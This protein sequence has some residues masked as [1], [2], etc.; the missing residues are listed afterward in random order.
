M[1]FILYFTQ[2]YFINSLSYVY[3]IG[4]TVQ[5]FSK[6]I[7]FTAFLKRVLYFMTD[8]WIAIDDRFL[9][10]RDIVLYIFTPFLDCDKKYFPA[11][12]RISCRSAKEVRRSCSN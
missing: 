6:K 10:H 9:R 11:K 12:L 3:K 8:I 7:R 4:S 1:T 2:I 5:F